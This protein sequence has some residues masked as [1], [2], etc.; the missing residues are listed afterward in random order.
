MPRVASR[1]AVVEGIFIPK[2]TYVDVDTV[3]TH[4]YEKNWPNASEFDPTRFLNPEDSTSTK[5]GVSYV[6]FGYG[7]RYCIG[8]N[9]TLYEQRIFLSMLCK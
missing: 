8:Y 6:T 1:D 9:F 3:A 4:M 5:E 7:S 2:G